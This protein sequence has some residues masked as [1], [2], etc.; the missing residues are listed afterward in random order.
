MQPSLNAV[1]QQLKARPDITHDFT[2][3][4]VNPL[5]IGW[6][7]TNMDHLRTF[8]THDEWRLLNRVVTD[9]NDQIGAINGF[10]NIVTLAQRGRS[11]VKLASARRCSLTHLRGEEW[12]LRTA[13]KTSDPRRAPRTGRRSTEHNQRPLCLEDHFG[14]SIQRGTMGYRNL[15]R[16]LLHHCY[17]FALFASYVLRQLE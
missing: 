3:R 4:K 9:G 17:S 14:S 5:H 13:N 11:H 1:S 2:L 10:M 8:R 6:R 16:V 12:N 7:V 15:N